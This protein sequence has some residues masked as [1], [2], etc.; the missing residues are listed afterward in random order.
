MLDW[1]ISSPQMMT[2]LGCAGTVW[3]IAAVVD[4]KAA[5]IPTPIAV[6]IRLYVMLPPS[7]QPVNRQPITPPAR[8]VD[9]RH[10]C[11]G[12]EQRLDHADHDHR[13]DD[14]QEHRPGERDG[15]QQP[16]QHRHQA[17]VLE[18]REAE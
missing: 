9:S 4:S 10:W 18:Q 13:A 17:I 16:A 7:S 14:Q 3:A 8:R 1:P 11:L 2:M 6:S 12:L 5:P 15:G